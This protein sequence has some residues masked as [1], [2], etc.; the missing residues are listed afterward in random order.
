M[1]V[2]EI[3]SEMDIAIQGMVEALESITKD[4][5]MWE[6]KYCKDIAEGALDVWRKANK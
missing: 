6:C 4:T 3:S 2:K 1:K 5:D